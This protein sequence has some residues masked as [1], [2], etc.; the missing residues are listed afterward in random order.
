MESYKTQDII[1][2][3][4][5]I[6]SKKNNFLEKSKSFSTLPIHEKEQINN[7]KKINLNFSETNNT[8]IILLKAA[9][10]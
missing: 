6:K 5:I 4:S 10:K 7:S 3:D 8:L 1:G 2:I 9:K